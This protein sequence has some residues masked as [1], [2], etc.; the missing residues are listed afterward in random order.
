MREKHTTEKIC[1]YYMYSKPFTQIFAQVR[2]KNTQKQR[3]M[4][5]IFQTIQANSVRYSNHIPRGLLLTLHNVG[6]VYWFSQTSKKYSP[7]QFSWN[8]NIDGTFCIHWWNLLYTLMDPFVYIDGTFC[9]H[10]WNLLYTL[11]EP[12]VYIDGTFCIHQSLFDTE[13]KLSAIF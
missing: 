5:A 10:W 1:E 3:Y 11:M 9:I 8:N 7:A 13:H 6:Q 12:F 4:L 2:V